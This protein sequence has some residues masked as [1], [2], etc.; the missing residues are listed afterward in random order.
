MQHVRTTLFL[1]I[2]SEAYISDL[3]LGATYI[4]GLAGL[5]KSMDA[6]AVVPVVSALLGPVVGLA[7]A[8]AVLGHFRLA[9]MKYLALS[10]TDWLLKCYGQRSES[11]T[12]PVFSKVT[13]Y[14]KPSLSQLF[15]AG[16]PVVKQATFE[17][18]S[19]EALGGWEIHAQNGT[20]DNVATSEL[21][22]FQQIRAFLSYLPSSIFALPPI[23]ATADPS[24]RREEQ[25]ISIIPR[26]RARPY[27]VRKL[28][29]L[30]VDID[31]TSENSTTFFE[32]GATWGR[33]IVTGFARLSGRP[34]GVLA[35]DC[36][37]NGGTLVTNSIGLILTGVN[38]EQLMPW[39]VKRPRDSQIFV[40]ISGKLT[41]PVFGSLS[42]R[43]SSQNSNFEFGRSPW[44]C[45]W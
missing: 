40:T 19:K 37:F 1:H 25:L 27:D 45:Y 15:A 30:I 11:G 4:P 18:L 24:N 6:M 36:M 39:G 7:A 22:A 13:V 42:L 38:Q 34:I 41:H 20:V 35:S 2:V 5:G 3:T 26:R 14:S 43:S 17:D 21:D 29:S 44:V 23:H 10:V 33:C 31:G 12:Y 16:P 28:I 8:K 32:I 9:S